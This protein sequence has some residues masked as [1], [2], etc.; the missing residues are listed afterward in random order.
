M[1]FLL[2][3]IDSVC[4]YGDLKWSSLILLIE[5]VQFSQHYFLETVLSPL[6]S[7]ASFVMD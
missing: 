2:I 5:T 4:I 1:D 6:Y 7:L 3:H